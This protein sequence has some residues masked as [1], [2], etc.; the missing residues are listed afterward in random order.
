MR[1]D[2]DLFPPAFLYPFLLPRRTS[3]SQREFHPYNLRRPRPIEKKLIF[4][5]FF[6]KK[7]EKESF[8]KIAPFYKNPFS[9]S[10]FPSLHTASINFCVFKNKVFFS[11]QFGLIEQIYA[12]PLFRQK[13][14]TMTFEAGS[15]T[16]NKEN[17]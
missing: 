9:L 15:K 11:L 13:S 1:P 10:F 2:L 4:I 6:K 8:E 5:F 12:I 17:G 3:V 14:K 7:E 16:D